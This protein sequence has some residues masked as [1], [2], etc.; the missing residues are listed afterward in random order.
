MGKTA[1]SLKM[2]NSR[3]AVCVLAGGRWCFDLKL[4]KA[5]I[6]KLRT[7]RNLSI[8]LV[9]ACW[10]ENVFVLFNDKTIFFSFI[11]FCEKWPYMAFGGFL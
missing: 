10:E 1:H 8:I 7:N 4:F 11:P 6:M 9:W 5:I 2:D 3:V